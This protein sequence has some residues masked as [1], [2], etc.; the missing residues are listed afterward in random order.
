MYSRRFI[1][2]PLIAVLGL[3]AIVV[4]APRDGA[5]EAFAP[6]PPNVGA[7]AAGATLSGGGLS[8]AGEP[9]SG[10]PS[11]G[12]AT[13]DAPAPT[14]GPS[15]AATADGDALAA[16]RALKHFC[17]LIGDGDRREAGRLLAGPWVWPRKEFAPIARLRFLSASVQGEDLAGDVVLRARV[18]A[19]LRGPSPLRDG[20]NTLFFTLGRDGTTGGWLITAVTTSP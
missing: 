17:D 5:G 19:R 4:L 16:V 12:A 15:P 2:L 8:G 9:L 7:P 18:R 3:A 20:I 10:P 14:G 1:A 13:T 6:S 11:I